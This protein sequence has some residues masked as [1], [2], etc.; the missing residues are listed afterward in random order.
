MNVLMKPFRLKP[1][2]VF[3]GVFLAAAVLAG[4]V[5]AVPTQAEESQ[6]ISR[7]EDWEAFQEKDG[8][9]TVC[10]IGSAPTKSRG[11]YKKRGET[12]V[13]ITHRPAEKK[14]AVVSIKAGY[15]YQQESE[16]DVIIGPKTFKLFTDAG[17]AFAYDAKGD[18]ALVK[19]MVRGAK[20][21]I[22]GTS[23]RGTPTTDTYSL[24][25]FT[26]AYKAINQACKV[27]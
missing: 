25:G 2:R 27:K 18:K 6:L 13:L 9:E 16:V 26:A 3:S 11:K 12:Y 15:T 23:S 22:K 7:Y 17:H 10:Y 21:V 5:S 24:K 4:P 20:M 19:A 1:G 14:L 8:G